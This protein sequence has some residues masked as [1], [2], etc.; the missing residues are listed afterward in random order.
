MPKIDFTYTAGAL[1]ATAKA[2]LPGKLAA[3]LLRAER[4][5]DTE[6]FRSISWTH[7][8]EL[9]ADAVH[10]ADGQSEKPQFVL[11]VTT[12]QGALSDRRRAEMVKEATD[13]VVEA[14]GLAPEDSLNVWVLHREINEGSWGAAGNVIQF[15]QLKAAAL[16]EREKAEAPA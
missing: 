16:A 9:P 1:D 12:P 6:F 2:E 14:A 5:P 13:L 3:A 4:A 7:V 11:E 15:E 10:T 8:H